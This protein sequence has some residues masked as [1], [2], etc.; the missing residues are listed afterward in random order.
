MCFTKE[1]QCKVVG[2]LE[3]GEVSVSSH[4]VQYTENTRIVS[5]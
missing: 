3:Y 1:S 4:G 2:L 5:L